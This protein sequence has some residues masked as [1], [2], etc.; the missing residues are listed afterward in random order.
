MCN[1]FFVLSGLFIGKS[2]I[3]GLER[4]ILNSINYFI[5]KK[6]FLIVFFF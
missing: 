2:I 4:K 5:D 6:R 1:I 3:E